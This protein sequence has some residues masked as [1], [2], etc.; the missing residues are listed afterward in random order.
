MNKP[1]AA[2]DFLAPPS[3]VRGV[4]AS[5]IAGWLL[6]G[7]SDMRANPI[8]SI[9]YGLLFAIGGDLILLAS[10]NH[11]RLFLF[12]V[13]GF[14]LLAPL[15]AVGLYELSR[16][17]TAGARPTFIDSLKAFKDNPRTVVLFGLL[18]AAITVLWERASAYSF[19]LFGDMSGINIGRFVIRMLA[20]GHHGGVVLLWFAA[21][22]LLALLAYAMSVVSLPLML[23]RKADIATAIGASVRTFAANTGTLLLWAVSIVVLTLFGFATLL[24]GLIVVM[25]VLAHA[26]WHAYRDLVK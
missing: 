12:A 7:W 20:G 17:R 2:T 26:S 23:D 1:P 13:S 3:A 5:A 19:A 21:G 14:F 16:Q 9:A 8:P 4:P 11:P 6:A 25:P 24:F 18:L 15:L 10:L 22:A